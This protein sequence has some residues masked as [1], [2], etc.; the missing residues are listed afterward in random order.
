MEFVGWWREN[1]KRHGQQALRES[2]CE[3]VAMVSAGVGM[4]GGLRRRALTFH[5]GVGS[6]IC[7]QSEER[8][9]LVAA[10]WARG[11]PGARNGRRFVQGKAGPIVFRVGM[12]GYVRFPY[13]RYFCW[14]LA[15]PQ[16]L[17]DRD[18]PIFVGRLLSTPGPRF[19]VA[20]SG[21]GLRSRA[22]RHCARAACA[23]DTGSKRQRSTS[24]TTARQ[25][26]PSGNKLQRLGCRRREKVWT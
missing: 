10:A 5:S 18:L 6:E 8:A 25:R 15:Q 1:D 16:M 12:F 14:S 2:R 3:R 20:K 7:I 4:C 23:T 13:V 9:E 11:T 22:R 26:E 24:T 19:C 21:A 17:P